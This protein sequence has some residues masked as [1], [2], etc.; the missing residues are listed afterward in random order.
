M[1]KNFSTFNENTSQITSPE[2]LKGNLYDGKDTTYGGGTMD[3]EDF[4]F[5]SKRRQEDIIK[6]ASEHGWSNVKD[7]IIYFASS[8]F[9]EKRIEFKAT[10]SK[11]TPWM[12]KGEVIFMNIALDYDDYYMVWLLYKYTYYEYKCDRLPGLKELIEDISTKF[13]IKIN[14][15]RRRRQK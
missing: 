13:P 15:G 9:N 14:R 5:I 11:D 1:I 2:P 8:S 4:D 12:D 10:A 6:F 3:L 7:P